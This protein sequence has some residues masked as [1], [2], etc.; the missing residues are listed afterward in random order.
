MRSHGRSRNISYPVPRV[1]QGDIHRRRRGAAR[2]LRVDGGGYLPGL[3][4][5]RG[6]LCFWTGH[7]SACIPYH[8][9]GP[10]PS[11]KPGSPS[12]EDGALRPVDIPSPSPRPGSPSH[13][14]GALRPVDMLDSSSVLR[15]SAVLFQSY[16]CCSMGSFLMFR[17]STQKG[18]L[19]PIVGLKWVFV[20]DVALVF[21]FCL[22]FYCIDLQ[23]W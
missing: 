21:G 14:D 7:G 8:L 10:S 6:S 22:L 9:P 23:R 17:F 11:P 18:I 19:R 16:L 3:P 13:E 4:S 20:L 2:R 15:P 12:Y 5:G 1:V